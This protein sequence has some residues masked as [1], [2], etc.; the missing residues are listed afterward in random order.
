M[1][2][3]SALL[4]GLMFVTGA[5]EAQSASAVRVAFESCD[6][7]LEA[8]VRAATELEFR[9]LAPT[10]LEHLR[11][12]EGVTLACAPA[13][14]ELRID[15]R[16][17]LSQVIDRS[18]LTAGSRGRILALT[19]AELLSA[20]DET[21]R[22]QQDQATVAPT[23]FV[24]RWGLQLGVLA[25]RSGSPGMRRV[26]G[27]VRGTY[28]AKRWLG[29]DL[30]FGGGKGRAVVDEGTVSSRWFSAAAALALIAGRRSVT[31]SFGL[32]YRVTTA[33]W[34]G[35]S[36]STTQLGLSGRAFW[37]G[38][39][40]RGGTALRLGRFVASLWGEVGYAFAAE[41]LADE[42]VVFSAGGLWGSGGVSCGLTFP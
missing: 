4:L 31:A 2:A 27:L 17:P 20:W 24:P 35:R 37:S 16:S 28:Q 40:L 13:A 25:L 42:R 39:F 9:T 41:G 33:L 15:G 14:L 12:G 34:R 3:L 18:T 32:G 8:E 21:R 5:A 10:V 7:E 38:P 11:P 36:N 22:L 6:A 23:P 29:F 19:A 1:K 26:G 30:E